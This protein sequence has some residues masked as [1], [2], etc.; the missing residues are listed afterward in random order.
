MIKPIQPNLFTKKIE[1]STENQT[2]NKNLSKA[3]ENNET[4]LVNAYYVP[5]NITFKH[6]K[7]E[8]SSKPVETTANYLN[9]VNKTDFE[10]SEI[11]VFEYPD[12]KL[13]L[14]LNS[15]DVDNS[16]VNK[17]AVKLFLSKNHKDYDDKKS[18]I[19]ADMLNKELKSQNSKFKLVQDSQGY[20]FDGNIDKSELDEIKD[21][22]K[23]ISDPK[24]SEQEF[25][26][27]KNALKSLIGDDKKLAEI[28]LESIKKY[29]NETL[30]AAEAQYFVTLDESVYENNKTSL[31]KYIN[32]DLSVEFTPHSEVSSK[33]FIPNA[34]LKI[35]HINSN[36]KN[37]EMLYPI[38]T[39]TAKDFLTA[40][41]S[42]LVLTMSR[43]SDF[44]C[45]AEIIESD[46][47]E[48]AAIPSNTYYIKTQISPKPEEDVLNLKNE[49]ELQKA[50]LG[51]YK[52]DN[53]AISYILDAT[54]PYLK[55]LIQE[56]LNSSDFEKSNE[57]LYRYKYDIYN[58][59]E[60][61]DSIESKDI[62]QYIKKYLSDQ[63]PVVKEGF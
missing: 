3:A 2:Q 58:L 54:K 9:G 12:T 28:N 16:G 17:V 46:M 47:Y 36:D 43:N 4:S 20:V 59:G 52:E 50:Y 35:I 7:A 34:E 31:F 10:K 60:K 5:L 19:L 62:A 42:T 22:N 55:K 39:D 38:K 6:R 37:I 1:Y 61:I 32:E 63:Q 51:R 18:F 26:A 14:F 33:D 56:D 44:E 57:V 21:L 8:N 40:L 15:N 30:T 23:F 11:H 24:F 41:F 25:E 49:M 48:N 27:S 45:D 29:Y 53:E 13:Q